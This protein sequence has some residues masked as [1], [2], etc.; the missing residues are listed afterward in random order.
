[1][2]NTAK[3]LLFAACIERVDA[4]K[5]LLF[6]ANGNLGSSVLYQLTASGHEVTCFV[7]SEKRLRAGFND[8]IFDDVVV[9]EG[10]ARDRADVDAV[11]AGAVYDVAVSTAGSVDN[12]VRNVD[13]ARATPF[14]CI[15]DNIAG[16]AE[17]HLP[18]PRRALFIGGITA[19]DLP[20]V[21]RPLQSL[22]SSRSPQ[23][24]AHL[25]NHDRLVRSSLDW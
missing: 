7:K 15:F 24:D 25:L 12:D 18:P 22:L 5:V 17:E 23:Y 3:L 9:I 6:G 10:D 16:A 11:M 21:G 14:C 13:E 20:G 8:R 1:M 2:A 4:L 19:L